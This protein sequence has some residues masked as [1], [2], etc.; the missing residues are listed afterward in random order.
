MMGEH[1]GQEI[2]SPSLTD[3]LR[4]AMS[5]VTSL[6]LVTVALA[7]TLPSRQAAAR[8]GPPDLVPRPG[9]D[10]VVQR[11][12]TSIYLRSDARGLTFGAGAATGGER[13]ALGLRLV[14]HQVS[15]RDPDL[16]LQ[17]EPTGLSALDL[18]LVLGGLS[19]RDPLGEACRQRGIKKDD[20]YP[21]NLPEDDQDGY[22]QSGGGPMGPRTFVLL[23]G[24]VGFQQLT[25]REAA[26]GWLAQ[27][28]GY[29][30]F[31]GRLGLGSFL[32]KETLLGISVGFQ[33]LGSAPARPSVCLP[34]D[35]TSVSSVYT[36]RDSYLGPF[37]R[38]DTV[39]LRVEWRWV[40]R[41]IMVAP[42]LRLVGA[43]SAADE[44]ETANDDRAR[45][46]QYVDLEIPFFI[47]DDS[48]AGLW[49]GGVE[50]VTRT[51]LV[52]RPQRVDAR[53]MAIVSWSLRRDRQRN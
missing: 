52:D 29:V 31:R 7:A 43:R 24:G 23:S 33:R 36:C 2:V 5:A 20:C 39:D 18:T 46:L 51:W 14:R 49:H 25:Y 40:G 34:A 45:R 9:R 19:Y 35:F 16:F 3:I 41:E 38:T 32:S 12:P 27:G 6:L 10:D 48:S 44:I 11:P 15:R 4:R 53:L 22:H 47:F 17:R 13:W 1:L 26:T 30:G 42:A 28:D 37:Q 21:G 50:I 8:Y